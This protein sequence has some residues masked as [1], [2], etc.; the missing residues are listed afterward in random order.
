MTWHK[1]AEEIDETL[2]DDNQSGI[3]LATVVMLL[4]HPT[5]RILIYTNKAN[6]GLNIGHRHKNVAA[7]PRRQQSSET[8]TMRAQPV[9][10]IHTQ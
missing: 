10:F 3:Y 4:F 6:V 5:S 1:F 9:S 7:P 8:G 2:I